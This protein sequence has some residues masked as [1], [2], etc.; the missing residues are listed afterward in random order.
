MSLWK[1]PVPYTNYIEEIRGFQLTIADIKKLKEGDVLDIVCFDY[2]VDT[3]TNHNLVNK[4]L[5]AN[6]FFKYI[7]QA[8]YIHKNG[9]EGMIQF[10]NIDIITRKFE[11]SI[12]C[13]ENNWYPLQYG[14]V[15]PNYYDY[16]LYPEYYNKLWTDFPDTIRVSCM[17]GP[18]VLKKHMKYLPRVYKNDTNELYEKICNIMNN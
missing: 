8:K 12:E 10:K 7:N 14:K 3:L 15:L 2:N 13:R 4:I 16:Y 1:Y 6:T 17:I 9:L 11:F 5:S 18:I